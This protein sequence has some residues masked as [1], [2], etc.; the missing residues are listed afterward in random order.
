LHIYAY[1]ERCHFYPKDA[2]L[3]LWPCRS[4]SML[5]ACP[6]RPYWESMLCPYCV[7]FL[8]FS[9]TRTRLSWVFGFGLRIIV[10]YFCGAFIRLLSSRDMVYVVHLSL[11]Y[12]DLL[13]HICLFWAVPLLSKGC[14]PSPLALSFLVDASRLSKT[15]LLRV[16]VTS[17]L[18]SLPLISF[19]L[20]LLFVS[21][22]RCIDGETC[23]W[24]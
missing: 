3:V 2:V 15:S 1:S 23:W 11:I 13:A 10:I 4:W 5:R 19:T 6:R 22:G 14:C 18:C 21:N 7:H 9:S 8:L 17:L 16:N 24:I 20:F 12:F